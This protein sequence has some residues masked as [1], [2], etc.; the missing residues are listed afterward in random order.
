MTEILHPKDIKSFKVEINGADFTYDVA[1]IEIY[2]DIFLPFWTASIIITDLN[3]QLMH[4]RIIQGDEVSIRVED[5]TNKTFKFI[6]HQIGERELVKQD[7]YVYELKCISSS[8]FK[9]Q[10]QRVWKH[11]EDKTAS[12][13]AKEVLAL[14]GGVDKVAGTSKSYSFI[15]PNL[16]PMATAQWVAQWGYRAASGADIFVYQSAPEK[17][18]FQSLERMFSDTSTALPRLTQIPANLKEENGAE[19][20]DSFISMEQYRFVN[21][22]NAIVNTT[23]GSFGNNVISHDIIKRKAETKSYTYSQDNSQDAKNKPFK[24]FKNL[25]MANIQYQPLHK[26][27]I[28]EDKYNFSEDFE[29]WRGSR[30]C[31]MAKLDTN[32]LLV[33][34]PGMIALADDLGKSVRV[35]LPAQ[36]D[37]D[38][39]ILLDEYYK[40]D[41]VI[42]AMRH[43][44]T[45]KRYNTFIEFGK[46]RLEK[47]I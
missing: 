47:T 5:K 21:H 4:K 1:Q 10:Q 8:Y 11:F 38:K 34:I 37:I 36:Q 6:I 15:V 29:K 30:K 24:R 44:I 20:A 22:M 27:N 26:G 19:Y 42:L 16:S 33:D 35:E 9:D 39:S 13:T 12:D 2:Q 31:N 40:F 3:N 32:R 7:H 17:F 23:T 14:I 45:Q 28:E 25:E 46:K 18:S 43:I 41:Y